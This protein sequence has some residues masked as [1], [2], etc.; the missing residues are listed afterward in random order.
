[1]RQAN[2]FRTTLTTI[3]FYTPEHDNDTILGWF[4]DWNPN[5]VAFARKYL[6]ISDDEGAVA[7]MMRGA[8]TSVC[9]TVIYQMQDILELGN[10]SRMNEPA[11]ISGNWQWRMLPGMLTKGRIRFLYDLTK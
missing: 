3:P 1:M 8:A 5:E 10:E 7:G 2:T 9:R 6:G 4:E 11:T